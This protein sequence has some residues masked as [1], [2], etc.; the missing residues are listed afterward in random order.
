M[1]KYKSRRYKM[2]ASA[3][4]SKTKPSVQPLP[5]G[6]PSILP[7]IDTNVFSGIDLMALLENAPKKPLED[8]AVSVKS[9]IS[10][11]SI[12][13]DQVIPKK[14]KRK[15]RRQLLLRRIDTVNQLK[16]EQSSKEK[17]PKNVQNDTLGDMQNLFNSL[18]NLES[19]AVSKTCSSQHTK[20]KRKAVEKSRKIQKMNT[21]QVNIYKQLLKNPAIK[22]DPFGTITQHLKTVVE[23]ERK[24]LV[25]STERPKKGAE[26]K[27]KKNKSK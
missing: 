19:L 15:L 11:K 14:E 13:G 12:K 27:K 4:S 23:K 21:K 25:E 6:P 3:A 5:E 16:K 9:C 18:P 1:G 26:Q 8:D 17:K 2:H 7:P 20:T 24:T 22:K 10:N